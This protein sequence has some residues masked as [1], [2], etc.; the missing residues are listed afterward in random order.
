[1][2][3]KGTSVIVTVLLF[4]IVLGFLSM[5]GPKPVIGEGQP[6]IPYGPNGEIP[7]GY[8]DPVAYDQI[9]IGEVEIDPSDT[10]PIRDYTENEIMAHMQSNSYSPFGFEKYSSHFHTLG[11]ANVCLGNSE[12][13]PQTA[14]HNVNIPYGSRIIYIEFSGIDTSNNASMVISFRRTHYSG[15]SNKAIAILDSGNSETYEDYFIIGKSIDHV[16]IN[17]FYSY[18]LHATFPDYD[19]VPTNRVG[20]CQ[21]TIYYYPPSPFVN[22]L[23][24]ISSN[25]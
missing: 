15:S 10:Q 25:K 11:N 5:S 7:F 9:S 14:Y 22:A 8:A 1:M 4:A 6:P 3:K 2:L 24:N 13:F 21:V 18:H 12:N 19:S 20:L 16:F 17:D 23:P